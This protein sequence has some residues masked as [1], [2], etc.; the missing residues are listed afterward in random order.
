MRLLI[1]TRCALGSQPVLDE[2]KP[3]GLGDVEIG[4]GRTG[5][6]NFH[7]DSGED[8]S[9]SHRNM[10]ISLHGDT[11]SGSPTQ[12]SMFWM[13]QQG[14]SQSA[15]APWDYWVLSSMHALQVHHGLRT[16]T[17]VLACVVWKALDVNRVGRGKLLA[18]N[19]PAECPAGALCTD[20]GFHRPLCTMKPLIQSARWQAAIGACGRLHRRNNLHVCCRQR[21]DEP[22]QSCCSSPALAIC[23]GVSA[24]CGY[25]T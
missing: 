8:V 3:V 22:S 16:F 1:A 23:G 10:G 12:P 21:A 5:S 14:V 24:S 7:S 20:M 9:T 17:I 4:L 15:P 2:N 19:R 18:A 25:G 11:V 6:A 13:S